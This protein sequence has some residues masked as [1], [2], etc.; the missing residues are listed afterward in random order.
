LL[1][2]PQLPNLRDAL[3]GE[4]IKVGCQV[5]ARQKPRKNWIEEEG[6]G[7]LIN[8]LPFENDQ[9]VVGERAQEW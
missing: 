7:M 4:I 9:S 2:H 1:T 5:R 3:C 8:S 6:S